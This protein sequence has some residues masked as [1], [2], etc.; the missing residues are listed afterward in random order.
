[1]DVTECE[2]DNVE[3]LEEERYKKTYGIMD[4]VIDEL[5]SEFEQKM[6][7]FAVGLTGEL[8]RKLEDSFP[9]VPIMYLYHEE[10]IKHYIGSKMSR[11]ALFSQGCNRY[12]VIKWILCPEDDGDIG[13]L[14]EN[15][16]KTKLEISQLEFNLLKEHAKRYLGK[17]PGALRKQPTIDR[18]RDIVEKGKLPHFVIVNKNL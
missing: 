17:N 9:N 14:L 4:G 15:N 1:M 5:R 16:N 2:T 10:E 7:E 13:R 12:D 8:R 3:F 18:A 11:Y 6:A